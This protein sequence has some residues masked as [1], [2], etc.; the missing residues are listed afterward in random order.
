MARM[1]P[2]RLRDSVT[3]SAERILY[4]AF[5][6]QLSN[7]ITVM[8]GVPLFERNPDD[9]DRDGEVD[10]VIVHPARGVLILEVK[11]GAVR[12]YGH[13]GKWYSRDRVGADHLIKDPFGQARTNLYA[14]MDKVQRASYT[15]RF[16]SEYRFQRGVAFPDIVIG[17]TYLGPDMHRDNII[18]R[19]D[20]DDLSSA[21]NRVLGKGPNGRM[22]S[23]GA[24]NG[25]VELLA[26]SWYI[27]RPRLG[28]DIDLGE[29]RWATLTEQQFEALESLKRFNRFAISGCAGSG[30]TFLAVE[31]A[32]RL[33]GEGYSVLFTCFNQ[34]LADWIRTELDCR[35]QGIGP[36]PYVDNYHDVA[37]EF[38][39]RAGMTLP[40][41]G[42]WQADRKQR[43]FDEELPEK[44]LDALNVVE[45]RFDAIVVDEAQDFKSNWWIALLSALKDPDN[46]PLYIFYDSNQCIYASDAEFPIPEPHIEL[47]TNCRNTQAIH[48]LAMTYHSDPP[49]LRCKG[50]EGRNPERVR[51]EPGNELVALK[52]V[53]S[54]LINEEKVAIPHIV[55]LTPRSARSSVLKEG[56]P[57]GNGLTL[58][59]REGGPG[60]LTVRSVHGYK[61]LEAPV[62]ILVEPY[63]AYTDLADQVMYIALSRARDHLIVL[64]K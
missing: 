10:F 64:D 1:F 47:N 51:V 24:I 5:R 31:K 2:E 58:T 18:D 27:E 34:A 19:T 62:V 12:R 44:F 60:K 35:L 48:K 29:K 55:V 38:C 33:V 56:T 22:L 25:L 59:W 7:E 20:L 37:A 16:A 11:G 26:P 42:S 13:T 36:V 54:Q 28:T 8:H 23:Q 61:G 15:A 9:F 39:R 49:S 41:V 63:K 4:D 40:N 14:L 46:S 21:V 17:N 43:Y 45:R 3:S 52:K 53:V 50:P 30:K 6:G 32:R 57:I